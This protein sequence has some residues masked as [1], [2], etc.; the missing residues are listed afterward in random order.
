MKN[1]IYQPW[2]GLGDNLAHSIIPE[3]CNKAGLPCFLSNQNACKNSEIKELVWDNNPFITGRVDST[4]MSWLDQIKPF[5]TP[6]S[7]HIEAIQRVYGFEPISKYPQ[8]Y[9]SPK[10]IIDAKDISIVDLSAHSISGDFV[11]SIDKLKELVKSVSNNP[12]TYFI[13]NDKLD[14][15][16]S[17]NSVM[18]ELPKIK[19]TSLFDYAD[20]L[21]S[22]KQFITLHSG[23]HILAAT[24]KN[25]LQSDLQID[26]FSFRKYLD[27]VDYNFPNVN[28]I[29]LN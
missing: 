8:I 3:L 22:V 18:G 15:G 21:G 6:G 4:D 19:I 26:T 7:N 14:Y 13:I 24:I 5:E 28:Y 12:K 11:N 10:H 29:S 9:Y 16:K 23:A 1:I 20:Y 25:K 27:R 17:F 2:G